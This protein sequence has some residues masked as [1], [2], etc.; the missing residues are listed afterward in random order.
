MRALRT[1]LEAGEPIVFAPP[2]LR[3][4]IVN[5]AGRRRRRGETAP[6]KACV[7]FG[8]TAAKV[9]GDRGGRVRTKSVRRGSTR[10]GSCHCA[11]TGRLVDGQVLARRSRR[12]LSPTVR[13]NRR[14]RVRTL[15]GAHDQLHGRVHRRRLASRAGRH[16]A[17]GPGGPYA[18]DL[19]P[20]APEDPGES[21][22]GTATPSG[23]TFASLPPCAYLLDTSV[24]ALL[25]TGDS[26]PLPLY[27]Y[28]AFCKGVE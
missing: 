3:L 8:I 16:H 26:V 13:R 25:T 15:F 9:C 12:A 1:A 7:R 28:I 21:W 22:Y 14:A 4:G 27:D 20:N 11:D 2:L 24:T 23:W 6:S 19:S 10:L 18:F 5:V 17:A